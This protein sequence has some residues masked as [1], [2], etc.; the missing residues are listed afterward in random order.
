MSKLGGGTGP[1][2]YR[3]MPWL[4]WMAIGPKCGWWLL[5]EASGV[6]C[7]W[8]CVGWRVA[9]SPRVCSQATL[10]WQMGVPARFELASV[11]D[12]YWEASRRK[13]LIHPRVKNFPCKWTDAH[14][15]RM[16]H[17]HQILA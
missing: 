7:N 5:A 15:D 3:M 8:V 9:R 4:F 16:D 10:C 11:F 17:R 12:R 1:L 14:V 2:S 13:L 6:R